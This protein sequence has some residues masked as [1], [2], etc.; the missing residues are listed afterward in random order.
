[1][2]ILTKAAILAAIEAGEIEVDPF[3]PALINP[4]SLDVRLAPDVEWFNRGHGN[5]FDM[6]D[7]KW[8][9]I[10]F[11][12]EIGKDGLLFTPGTLLLAHTIERTFTPKHAPILFGKSSLSRMGLQV[13]ST[14][15]YSETGF[16]GQWTLALSCV[17]PVVLRAGLPIAQISF[18]TIEGEPT[19]YA[20]R[21]QNSVGVQSAKA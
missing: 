2:A 6:K 7:R 5:E 11:R 1:M 3:D 10:P 15:G 8:T 20:G 13:H 21:Y 18:N 19:A 4:N 9:G 12:G 16:D 14:G 17:V